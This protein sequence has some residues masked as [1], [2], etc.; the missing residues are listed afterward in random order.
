MEQTSIGERIKSKRKALGLTQIQI[1]QATGIS[2]GNLSDIENGN[3]LPS[4]PTLISLSN[5]L[6]CSIDWI[7][8][9]ETPK[10]ENDF[11]Q[12]ESITELNNLFM[13]LSNDDQ[14]ELL[15]IARIKSNK[16]KRNQNLK[17]S[18]SVN[19]KAFSETA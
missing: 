6:N 14:E 3:K 2:S 12:N 19:D 13:N 10:C 5:I 17:S 11:F 7:L 18:L 15:M 1:K 8:K 4:T 9:G 16:G